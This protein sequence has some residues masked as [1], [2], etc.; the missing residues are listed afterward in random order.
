MDLLPHLDLVLGRLVKALL[1][2]LLEVAHLLVTNQVH[3]GNA[4]DGLQRRVHHD[5][6]LQHNDPLDLHGLVGADLAC[7]G[8][9]EVHIVD[10]MDNVHID[11]K[12]EDVHRIH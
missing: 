9:E 4:D 10:G 3:M 11:R 2:H 5:A 6:D 12:I 7:T 1:H 8:R